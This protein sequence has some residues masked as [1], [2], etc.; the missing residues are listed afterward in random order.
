MCCCRC[1]CCQR[2]GPDPNPDIERRFKTLEKKIKELG[3]NVSATQDQ[4]N[5]LAVVLHQEDSDLNAAVTR[6]QAWIDNHPDLDLSELQA[7][8]GNLGSAVSSA[9]ALVPAPPAPPVEP[10]A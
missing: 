3:A 9:A 4:V 5:A 8:V 10:V 7:E 1:C 2:P 6:I